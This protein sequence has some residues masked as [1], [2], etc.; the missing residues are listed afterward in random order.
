MDERE[1]ITTCAESLKQIL[2]VAQQ[3]LFYLDD[4]DRELSLL[5]EKFKVLSLNHQQ[6]GK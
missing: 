2:T 4:K 3:T 5:R 1:I 6:E